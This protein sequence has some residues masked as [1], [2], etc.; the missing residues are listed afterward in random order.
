MARS[1]EE[2]RKMQDRMDQAAQTYHVNYVNR[3]PK[4]PESVKIRLKA[5]TEIGLVFIP[6]AL[7]SLASIISFIVISLARGSGRT[8]LRVSI[9]SGG[10]MTSLSCYFWYHV[11]WT[12]KKN[13]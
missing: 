10:L 7:I 3:L 12:E 4:D 8:M 9:A 13:S 5:A 6:L 11:F 2:S 1:R